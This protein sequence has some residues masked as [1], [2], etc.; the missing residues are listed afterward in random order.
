MSRI[1]GSNTSPERLLRLALWRRGYRYRLHARTPVG[2]PDIVFGRRK[3][4]VFVDGCFWHG[5]PEHYVRP[6]TRNAFWDAKLDE[7]FKRD[8]RQTLALIQAGWRVL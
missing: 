5:C 4:A 6:R 2:A 3:V 8:R 7:N 1:R